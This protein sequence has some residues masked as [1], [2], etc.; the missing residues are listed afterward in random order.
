M[1]HFARRAGIGAIVTALVLALPAAPAHAGTPQAPGTASRPVLSVAEAARF[2]PATYLERSGP[3]AAPVADPWRPGPVRPGRPDVV[4]RPGDSVQEAVDTVHR[5]GGD[6]RR[7]ILV[8]P[9]TYPG[10]VFIPA[11]GPPLTLHGVG[12]V[13]IEHSL[14]GAAS[15]ADWAAAVNPD[16]RYAEGDPAWAMYRSCAT[17]TQATVGLCASVV[18]SES[19]GLELAGLTIVNTLPDLAGTHQAVALR[20][21]ADRTLVERVRLVSR[22]D[23][24]HTNAADATRIARV[25]VRDSYVEG[26]TDFVF[27]RATAVFERVHFHVVSTRKPTDGVVFSPSTNPAHPFGFLVRHSL[28]TTDAGYDGA[29]TANLG[30]AW[31]QSAGSTGYLPG[32]SPNGQLVIR[33]SAIDGGFDPVAPW[34]P[35]ATTGRPFAGNVTDGRDL[36]DPAFNRLWEYRTV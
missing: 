26:D 2:T 34:A 23:T 17:R 32:V 6:R 18:W 21:D 9:G 19:P 28:L 36:D 13:R 3:Y 1:A 5:L 30:R 25:V 10:T 15:P 27:G 24:F 11:G 12:D 22:Q 8:T 33:E 16:G 20:T 14:D 35:A 4:V 7:Y 31:D 29:P